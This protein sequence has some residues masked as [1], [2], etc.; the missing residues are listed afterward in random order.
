MA[1]DCIS[2]TYWVVITHMAHDGIFP[3]N[4]VT[5][6]STST[7]RRWEG[8]VDKFVLIFR[9]LV[10]IDV[11]IVW[12]VCAGWIHSPYMGITKWPFMYRGHFS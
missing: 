10:T 4:H 8:T 3:S 9:L 6:V 7:K 2:V 1:M 11:D 12:T 5:S